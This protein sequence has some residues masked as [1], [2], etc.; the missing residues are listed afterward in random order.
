MSIIFTAL[1]LTLCISPPAE[2]LSRE[3]Y[4]SKVWRYDYEC[5]LNYVLSDEEIQK[6][7]SVAEKVKGE[8]CKDTAWKILEWEDENLVYDV[9]KANLPPP[10][11]EIRGGEV[12][13]YNTGRYI[14]TP[15]ETIM[16]GKGIC[17]DYAFLTLAL[18]RYK[19]L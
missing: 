12:E 15:S 4:C 18:L 9:E 8:D 14:Q 7:A 17:T 3:E 6:V 16:L 2:E 5:A 1:L 19:R 13:V 10:Q 11:I